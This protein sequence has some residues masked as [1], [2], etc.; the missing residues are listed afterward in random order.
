MLSPF[1]C[2]NPFYLFALPQPP[3]IIMTPRLR[4]RTAQ[5]KHDMVL[6]MTCQYAGKFIFTRKGTTAKNVMSHRYA[7]A[8]LDSA[9]NPHLQCI[10]L[11]AEELACLNQVVPPAREKGLDVAHLFPNKPED[12]SLR[13]FSVALECLF[14][15]LELGL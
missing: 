13:A 2:I 3:E 4:T 11:A 6:Q 7:H 15:R 12:F 1:N 8:L 9:R 5:R 10:L 14:E